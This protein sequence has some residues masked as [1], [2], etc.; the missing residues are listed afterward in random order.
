VYAEGQKLAADE[1]RAE[2]ERQQ[3]IAQEQSRV[4]SEQQQ[5]AAEG[6]AEAERER[7]VAESAQKMAE[8]QRRRAEEQTKVATSTLFNVIRFVRGTPEKRRAA[9][10]YNQLAQIYHE[11]GDRDNEAESLLS[12]AGIQLELRDEGGAA[13]YTERALKVFRDAGDAAG[14]GHTLTKI[15]DLYKGA[16]EAERAAVFYRQSLAR[17]GQALPAIRARA[18]T[19][20]E[21]YALYY[22]SLGQAA[23]GDYA[24]ALDSCRRALP[25]F[26]SLRDGV[27][28]DIVEIRVEELTQSLRG[29]DR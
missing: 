19:R 20:Q 3:Q 27:M 15:G 2:A 18:D 17:I 6:R 22:L 16:G 25:L 7:T 1:Q 11:I 12:A 4:A 21:A 13:A 29:K 26:R 5:V 8:G 14:E 23:L 28:S 24:Q 10:Y 9:E